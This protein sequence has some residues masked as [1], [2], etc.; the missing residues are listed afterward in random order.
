[1]SQIDDEAKRIRDDALARA[2]TVRIKADR[3]IAKNLLRIAWFIVR[4]GAAFAA[5]AFLF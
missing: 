5:G 4:Y 3:W 2:T 1:M